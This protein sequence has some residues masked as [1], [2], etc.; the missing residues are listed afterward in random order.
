MIMPWNRREVHMVTSMEEFNRICSIL[1]SK[2]VKYTFAG[3]KRRRNSMDYIYVHKDD[4]EE[5]QFVL[6]KR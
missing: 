5:A 3:R 2:N 6:L 1:A 4:F